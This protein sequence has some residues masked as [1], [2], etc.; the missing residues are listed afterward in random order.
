MKSSNT[1]QTLLPVKCLDLKNGGSSKR[2][3][4]I[5]LKYPLNLY[6][7]SFKTK[8]NKR[9][10][11][12]FHLGVCSFHPAMEFKKFSRIMGMFLPLLFSCL[13]FN[14]VNK[15]PS[16]WKTYCEMQSTSPEQHSPRS[17]YCCSFI[18]ITI[19]C[20]RNST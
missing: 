4:G 11:A 12:E 19:P 7:E 18:L 14:L 3:L 2:S 16:S 9:F 5:E 8:S 15:L 20:C 1:N 10:Q 13:L 6:T 17:P